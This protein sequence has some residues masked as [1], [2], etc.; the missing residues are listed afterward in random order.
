M[1]VIVADDER[2]VREGIVK[3]IS[4]RKYHIDTVLEAKTEQSVWN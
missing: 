3:S 1:L 2:F 4:W